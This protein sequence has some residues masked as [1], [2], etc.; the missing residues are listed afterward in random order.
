MRAG[1]LT[2]ALAAAVAMTGCASVMR[3][4]QTLSPAVAE[5][6]A[7]QTISIT[8][9]SGAVV[10]RGT[11][12]APAEVKGKITRTGE[13]TSPANAVAHATVAIEIEQQDGLRLEELRI[14]VANLACPGSCKLFLDTQQLI[15]FSTP[16]DGV[17]LLKMTRRVNPLPGAKRP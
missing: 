17:V 12:S 8:D 16:E 9:W 5:L 11:L 10:L 7:A 14:K 15:V 4:E 6:T 13:L 3:V 1:R 2:I